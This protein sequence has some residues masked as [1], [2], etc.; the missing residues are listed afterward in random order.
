VLKNV[1]AF[2]QEFLNFLQY[3]DQKDSLEKNGFTH[4]KEIIQNLWSLLDNEIDT[5][6]IANQLREFDKL[7]PRIFSDVVIEDL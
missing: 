1:Q 7:V 4:C 2:K 3:S 6:N 5:E